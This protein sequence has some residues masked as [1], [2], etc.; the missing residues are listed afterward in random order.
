MI[1]NTWINNELITLDTD[2]VWL[3]V[4]ATWD[5]LTDTETA[6]AIANAVTRELI[7]AETRD[8]AQS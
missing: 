6:A 5:A 7:A 8:E 1:V 3:E 2:A 4:F